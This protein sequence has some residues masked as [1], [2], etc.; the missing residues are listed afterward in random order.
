VLD[1]CLMVRP[2]AERLKRVLGDEATVL[3]DDHDGGDGRSLE[4]IAIHR[5][6]YLNAR[7]LAYSPLTVTT[8][9]TAPGAAGFES[10][11]D[12]VLVVSGNAF[13]VVHGIPRKLGDVAGTRLALPPGTSTGCIDGGSRRR[14]CSGGWTRSAK[15]SG[16]YDSMHHPT[17]C[18]AIPR[19]TREGKRFDSCESTSTCRTISRTWTTISERESPRSCSAATL[20]LTE[21][22]SASMKAKRSPS[23]GTTN[24]TGGP[25]AEIGKSFIERPGGGK[26]S[27]E[28]P[29][30]CHRSGSGVRAGGNVPH[31]ILSSSFF[32]SKRLVSN[33]GFRIKGFALPMRCENSPWMQPCYLLQQVAQGV[34][35]SAQPRSAPFFLPPAL[36]QSLAVK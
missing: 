33:K 24:G 16:R 1:L 11:H 14:G 10:R 15:T 26:A 34:I 13:V 27:P 36:Q 31:T 9:R 2:N 21:S 4:A 3:A 18:L 30:C 5:R 17:A 25:D 20:A 23:S 32:K 7:V 19:Y 35:S 29:G 28:A 22:R 6:L 8:A 12:L